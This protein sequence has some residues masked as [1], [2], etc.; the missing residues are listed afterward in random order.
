MI[1]GPSRARLENS[2][3]KSLGA[4]LKEERTSEIK[5]LLVESQEE[6]LKLLNPKTAENVREE[7]EVIT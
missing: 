4:S 5:G 2:V 6:L 3:L 7:N 1:V